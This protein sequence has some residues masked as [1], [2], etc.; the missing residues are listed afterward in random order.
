MQVNQKSLYIKDKMINISI[1][2][3]QCFSGKV[4]DL[5]SLLAKCGLYHKTCFKCDDCNKNLDAPFSKYQE[6]TTTAESDAG[7]GLYCQRCFEE[8][9]GSNPAPNIYAKT[10]AIVAVDGKGQNWNFIAKGFL[11]SGSVNPLTSAAPPEFST[12]E[13]NLDNAEKAN[14]TK[15]SQ[16]PS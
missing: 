5:E 4:F 15:Q 14:T 13:H 6:T 2:V 8:K 7:A 12:A 11:S 3:H 10:S 1:Y 16:C 9:F